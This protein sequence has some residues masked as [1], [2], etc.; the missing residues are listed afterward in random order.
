MPVSFVRALVA[1]TLVAAPLSA[2]LGPV[3]T[4]VREEAAVREVIGLYFRA[5]E[6]GDGAFIQQSFHPELKMMGVRNDSLIVRSAEQYWSGF[7]GR[8]AADEA[9]R[10]RWIDRVEV[11][12]HAANVRVVLDYPTVTYVDFFALLKING[13]WKIVSKVYATEAKPRPAP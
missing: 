4:N 1:L 2:Q 11:F 6:T 12:G 13:E 5:H 8:P 10:R 9:T 3:T 7:S